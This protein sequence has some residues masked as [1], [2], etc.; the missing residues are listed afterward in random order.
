MSICSP[1]KFGM[2][3]ETNDS[4]LERAFDC[5]LRV[6]QF[7]KAERQFHFALGRKYSA[8]FAWPDKKLL[9]E[10][11]GGI[12]KPGGGA[13]SHPL[14]IERDIEKYNLAT[15]EGWRV[16]RVTG[17]MLAKK[18]WPELSILMEKVLC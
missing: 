18:R 9:V 8:D 16:I 14:G 12:W 1:S 4:A 2:P 7:P 5:F 11:E 13:H 6:F 3:Q 17:K 10:I 15:A